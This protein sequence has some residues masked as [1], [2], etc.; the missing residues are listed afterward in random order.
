MLFL[1]E[2]IEYDIVKGNK[3]KQ[4]DIVNKRGVW[5]LHF[6]RRLKEPDQFQLEIRAVSAGD[7]KEEAEEALDFH[8][9]IQVVP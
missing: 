9:H 6:R 7:S 3:G 8:V 1:Q 5:S 4:F 2:Y